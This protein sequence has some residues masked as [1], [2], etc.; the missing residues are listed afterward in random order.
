[1][2]LWIGSLKGGNSGLSIYAKI[3][4]AYKDYRLFSGLRKQLAHHDG[5]LFLHDTHFSRAIPTKPRLLVYDCVDLPLMHQRTSKA[6]RNRHKYF[7]TFVDWHAKKAAR[8]AHI[9]TLTSPF[10]KRFLSHWLG[11]KINLVL[12]RNFTAIDF[13]ALKVN[14]EVQGFLKSKPE[15]RHW[16]VIH[17]RIGEFLDINGVLKAMNK[18]PK[19]WGLCFLGVFD[20]KISKVEIYN[21]VEQYC[22]NH[23]VMYHDALYGEAK[24]AALKCFD[25]GLVPL[26]SESQNLKRCIPNRSLEILGLGLPQVAYRTSALKS[27]S[28]EFPQKIFVPHKVGQDAFESTLNEVCKTIEQQKSSEPK[29]LPTWSGDFNLFRDVLNM[30]VKNKKLERHVTV[31]SENN[32]QR[33]NR[34]YNIQSGLKQQGYSVTVLEINMQNHTVTKHN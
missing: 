16:I 25:L 10:Y 15:I 13:D 19:H 32:P 18:L 9:I 6:R 7:R 28:E 11:K 1:M 30:E 14:Q 4:K 3:Q 22:P 2:K 34:L 24:L 26:V 5:V 23:T 33:N 17:N 27:L 31:L 8:K 20:E 12:L 21:R 29:K